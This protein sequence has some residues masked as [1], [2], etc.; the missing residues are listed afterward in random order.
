MKNLGYKGEY[1]D[2]FNIQQSLTAASRS[3][4]QAWLEENEYTFF[5]PPGVTESIDITPHIKFTSLIPE[6]HIQSQTHPD[7]P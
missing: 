4:S 6:L 5:L 2:L 1:A 3:S 7:S